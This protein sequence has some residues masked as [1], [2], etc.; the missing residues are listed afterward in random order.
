MVKRHLLDEI[1][2]RSEKSISDFRFD[3]NIVLF[4]K[5]IQ[6]IDPNDYALEEWSEV[7]HYIYDASIKFQTMDEVLKY[8]RID[9]R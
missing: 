3:E 9:K 6:E 5:F 1:A 2:F 4:R 8:L 7:I